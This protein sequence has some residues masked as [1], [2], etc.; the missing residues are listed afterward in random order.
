MLP[1]WNPQDIRNPPRGDSK[2]PDHQENQEAEGRPPSRIK[3]ILILM[4]ILLFNA[5]MLPF[6]NPLDIRT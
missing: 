1:Y 6:W 3:D 4:G 2:I 5:C